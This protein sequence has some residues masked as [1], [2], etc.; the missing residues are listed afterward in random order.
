MSLQG[1]CLQ[2]IQ[3]EYNTLSEVVMCFADRKCQCNE[4]MVKHQYIIIDRNLYNSAIYFRLYLF[5]MRSVDY[6]H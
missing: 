1:W 6:I 2:W 4:E 5:F 3:I